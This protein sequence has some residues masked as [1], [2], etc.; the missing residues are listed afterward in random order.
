MGTKTDS[1]ADP[2]ASTRARR[3]PAVS[4][5][6]LTPAEVASRLRISEMTLK[7]WRWLGQGPAYTKVGSAVRYGVDDVLAF[8]VAGESGSRNVGETP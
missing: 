5:A 7:N 2:A 3:G 1:T 8:E 4:V 6:Y